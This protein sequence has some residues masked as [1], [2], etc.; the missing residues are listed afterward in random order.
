MSRVRHETRA[1]SKS[2]VDDARCWTAQQQVMMKK[3]NKINQ[4]IYMG[5]LISH[6]VATFRTDVPDSLV[7]PT[8]ARFAPAIL[9]HH[10]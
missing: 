8:L 2:F 9:H 6:S 10:R 7:H 1:V 3:D 4:N 5:R